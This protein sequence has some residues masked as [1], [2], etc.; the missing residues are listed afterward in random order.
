MERDDLI[1]ELARA[2]RPYLPELLGDRAQE[3][4]RELADL[5]AD[6]GIG[7][8]RDQ[9]RRAILETLA[10]DWVTH[11][12]GSEFL[13]AGRPPGSQQHEIRTFEQVPGRPVPPPPLRYVCPKGDLSWYRRVVGESP[14]K[15]N[16]HGIDLVPAN[17]E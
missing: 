14:P 1:I 16:T 7:G 4:D 10:R 12:W 17:L 8:D 6:L 11:N 2:I 9:V 3:T 13:A 5:L 15:C